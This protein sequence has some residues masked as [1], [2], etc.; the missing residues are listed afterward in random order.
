MQW[1]IIN[2]KYFIW[3]KKP[4]LLVNKG[5]HKAK[6]DMSTACWQG[7]VYFKRKRS[8]SILLDNVIHFFCT[9]VCWK[10]CRTHCIFWHLSCFSIS[11]FKICLPNM[12]N[13]SPF[14]TPFPNKIATLFYG[15]SITQKDDNIAKICI[16]IGC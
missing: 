2:L 10:I 15:P 3:H 12:Q 5:L 13:F 9:F 7:K 14:L 4:I 11:S 8:H 1:K 16:K 6:H